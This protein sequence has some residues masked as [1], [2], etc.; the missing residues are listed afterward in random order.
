MDDRQKTVFLAIV[1]G[2]GA[3]FIVDAVESVRNAIAVLTFF[4]FYNY[5][6]NE[7]EK[8]KQKAIN[9]MLNEELRELRSKLERLER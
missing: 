8:D 6:A 7:I 3:Y 2:A 5:G 4:I 9:G 1:A